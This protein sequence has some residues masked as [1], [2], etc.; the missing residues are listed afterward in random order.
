MFL[1]SCHYFSAKLII[2]RET[3]AIRRLQKNFEVVDAVDS[4][5]T[6]VSYLAALAGGKYLYIPPATV[7]RVTQ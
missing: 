5:D 7:E 3:L 4:E 6:A 1:V 2:F